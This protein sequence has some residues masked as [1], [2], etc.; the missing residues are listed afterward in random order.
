MFGHISTVGYWNDLLCLIGSYSGTVDVS[1]LQYPILCNRGW[2]FT[3]IPSYVMHLA[4]IDPAW[5]QKN[6]NLFHVVK[7]P[8]LWSF[9]PLETTKCAT[10][11]ISTIPAQSQQA[12]FTYFHLL[13][14]W[15]ALLLQWSLPRRLYNSV[16]VCRL[17]TNSTQEI[18]KYWAGFSIGIVKQ[19]TRE[20]WICTRSFSWCGIRT[21]RK[22]SGNNCS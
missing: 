20:L 1:V 2:S 17:W 7:R 6:H 15:P 3:S 21:N 9:D 4:S 13:F 8:V 22:Q 19:T 14:G 12:I 16:S 11:F 10:V 18:V 5:R